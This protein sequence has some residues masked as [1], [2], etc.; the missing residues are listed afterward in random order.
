MEYSS[1][2]SLCRSALIAH[3]GDEN[4]GDAGRAHL[5]EA[6]ELLALDMIEQQDGA[7]EH[8]ALLDRFESAGGGELLGTHH[9]FH[10]AR[11]EFFHAA[12]ENDATAVD[13]HEIGE[14]VLDLFYLMGGH[15]NGAAA[16]EV[17]VQQGIV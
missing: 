1:S 12:I 14:H 16:V 17:V 9:Q 6:S 10:V 11:L 5:A 2:R 7:A 8:L 4:V 13:E 3:H 15:D